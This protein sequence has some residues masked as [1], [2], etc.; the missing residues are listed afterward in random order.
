VVAVAGPAGK[1]ALFDFR[2]APTAEFF[3]RKYT[4]WSA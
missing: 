1:F 4:F 3:A 2:F